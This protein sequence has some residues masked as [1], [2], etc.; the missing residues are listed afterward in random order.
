MAGGIFFVSWELW[1]QMTFV[2]AM[3]IV[4]VF[5]AGLGK[6]WWN[7]RLMKKQEV[8]DEERRA[9]VE[10]MRKTGLPIKR[11]NNIPF[12]VRAIQSGVEVDGIW[13]SRP[14]SLNDAPG[15]KLVS[16]TTL[17]SKDSDS[18]KNGRKYSGDERLVMAT[19]TNIGPR[20][21][22]SAASIFQK[23]TDSDSTKSAQSATEAPPGSQFAHKAKRQSSR[24]SGNLDEDTLR[25]LEGEAPSE[26]LYETYLP[27]A[28]SRP[29][30]QSPTTSSSAESVDS[31]PRSSGVRSHTSS[32]HSLSLYMA[33]NPQPHS[34]GAVSGN[35]AALRRDPFE[36]PRARTPSGLSQAEA[37]GALQ[38]QRSQSQ[39]VAAPERT[40]GVGVFRFNQAS[41]RVNDGFE[42]LPAGTF[43]TTPGMPGEGDRSPRSTNRLRKSTVQGDLE[44]GR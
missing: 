27:T 30:P 16:A 21:S 2:L 25:R 37:S 22:P 38:Q 14:A 13:I 28:S 18:Q 34:H 6:L 17:A 23:L 8:L 26:P 35:E 20:Q 5:C 43:G 24:P 42:V 9:R 4:G 36:T 31:Q 12:G 29:S 1:Q 41:R 11:A 19:T 32:S 15:A 3:A 40:F 44:G 10:E 33:R 39:V 7:N